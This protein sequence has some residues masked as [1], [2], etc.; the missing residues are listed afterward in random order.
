LG[1]KRF[2][3]RLRNLQMYSFANVSSLFHVKRGFNE[4]KIM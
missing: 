1:I 3:E 4:R 2:I